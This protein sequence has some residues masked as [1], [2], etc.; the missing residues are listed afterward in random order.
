M[1]S[2]FRVVG[3]CLLL[4]LAPGL[5]AASGP[6]SSAPVV[7][8]PS[9][10]LVAR[11]LAVVINESDPLSVAIG[12][13]YQSRRGIPAENVVRVRFD[14]TR[15]SLGA[16]E[17][18]RVRAEVAS[19]TPAHAQ[20]YALTWARPYRV[21]CMSITTAFAAGYQPAFC[22]ERCTATRWSPYFNSN[23]RR[24]FRDFGLRP[25]MSLAALDFERARELIDRGVAADGSMQKGK[26]YL[27]ST[28]DLARNV[29]S[30]TYPDAELMV[31]DQAPIE[32][33][34]TAALEGKQDVM[35]YFI[36][37][38]EVGKLPTNRFLPGAVGDHLT[39][40]GGDLTGV[41]QMSSLRW[42]EAGATGSYG[43]VTEP[44]NILGKFPNPGMMMKRYL[45]GETLIEAY[46]KSVAMPGQGLFIGE[47]LANPYG[48]Y[49]VMFDGRD[50]A[51]EARALPSGRYDIKGARD[52]AGP[53]VTIA[54]RIEYTRGVTLRIR[55]A[56]LPFYQIVAA[57]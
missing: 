28:T 33:L 18:A 4:A 16:Q 46:W 5:S 47:P 56:T 44:C 31:G 37:A 35:F 38:A 22:S 29:R 20:A 39:S 14:A 10:S 24:P 54:D 15:A 21:D 53:Y 23:S 8:L 3:L 11:D 26:A 48:G 2:A 50:L 43:A 52:A 32:R 57:L 49:R 27:V 41:M 19:R 55:D 42:L 13:Y 9:T 40:L 12:E 6:E 25:T 34:T 45:A 1:V 17:F 7:T 30:K 36:G 51:I